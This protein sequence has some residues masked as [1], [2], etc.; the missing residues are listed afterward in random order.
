MGHIQ[1]IFGYGPGKH[2]NGYRNEHECRNENEC[3]NESEYT[4]GNECRAS[5]MNMKAILVETIE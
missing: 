3:R 1:D 4:N 5:E 2:E